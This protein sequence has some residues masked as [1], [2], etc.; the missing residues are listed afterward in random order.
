LGFGGLR[1]GVRE[2]G[3]GGLGVGGLGVGVEWES[4]RYRGMSRAMALCVATSV[5]KSVCFSSFLSA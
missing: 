1:L 2:L 4:S 3:V 5:R